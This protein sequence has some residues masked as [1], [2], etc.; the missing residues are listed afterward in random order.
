MSDDVLSWSLATVAWERFG[1]GV[2]GPGE[3]GTIGIG[4]IVRG[5]VH[6]RTRDRVRISNLEDR[7]AVWTDGRTEPDSVLDGWCAVLC[8][9][10]E[11]KTLEMCPYT[12]KKILLERVSRDS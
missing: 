10:Q 6:K 3:V 4:K 1:R 8:A 2:C 9:R 11:E 12:Y 7:R 5:R